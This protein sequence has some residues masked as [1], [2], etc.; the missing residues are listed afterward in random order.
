MNYINKDFLVLSKKQ[1]DYLGDLK[2]MLKKQM[3]SELYNHTVGTL[4]YSEKLLSIHFLQLLKGEQK[5]KLL[6]LYYKLSLASLLHDYGKIFK[7]EEL[8]RIAVEENLGLSDF[9]LN[10]KPIIHGFVTPF[11]IKRDFDVVDFEIE[12]AIK[13]HTVGSCNMT[14][15]DKL[16]Y[17]SDK[18]EETRSYEG[19]DFLRRLSER[20]LSWCLLEVYKSNII[21]VTSKN[22]ML[23]PD[24]GRIWNYICGGLKNAI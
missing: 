3:P 17:I 2:E 5:N 9:E 20:D 12:Q 22:K 13:C 24:T 1:T 10:C 19:I 11:L 4:N 8:F 18:V 23:H 16:L 7:Y 15:I 14:I 6:R 21:Y